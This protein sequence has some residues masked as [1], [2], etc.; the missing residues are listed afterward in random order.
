MAKAPIRAASARPD[1]AETPKAQ[2]RG[3]SVIAIAA[4][5]VIAC[6]ASFL[7]VAVGFGHKG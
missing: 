1:P 7:L 3:R 2:S 6:V 5:F 4:A